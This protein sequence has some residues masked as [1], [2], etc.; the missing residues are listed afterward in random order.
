MGC[1]CGINRLP[2]QRT[3]GLPPGIPAGPV[4]LDPL[5]V[6]HLARRSADGTWR[7]LC[8]LAVP[9]D[10]RCPTDVELRAAGAWTLLS[11]GGCHHVYLAE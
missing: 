5:G 10:H 6:R 11:C 4:L 2:D 8:G 9:A 1:D 3:L 7:T